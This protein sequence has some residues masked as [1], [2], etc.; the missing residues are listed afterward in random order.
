MQLYVADYLGDTRHLT[1]EQHGAY[2][3]ILMTMWRSDG[4]LPNDPK[5]LARITGCNGSRWAR[6][7]PEVMEFFDVEGDQITNPRLRLELEKAQEKSNQRAVAG[8]KGGKANVLK[9]NNPVEANATALPNHSSEPEPDKEREANASAGS[10][11]MPTLL[12]HG[13][14]EA[15]TAKAAPWSADPNFAAAWAACTDKGRTRS[16]RKAAWAEWRKALRAAPGPVLAAAMARYVA[17]D[18]D[19]KRTGGP[20]F[21]IWLKDAKFEH[22]IGAPYAPD[23]APAAFNGPAALRESVVALMGEPF[24]RSWIDPCRWDAENRT[25]IARNGYAASKLNTELE[26]WMTRNKVKAAVLMQEAA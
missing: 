15:V 4:R 20:G 3:L 5:K 7:A 6:I 18:D 26:A 19:A 24:A 14:P 8:A 17:G 1:T 10:Q 25:L 11:A 9:N 23:F 13:E 2:L 22:W 12:D 16:S 21:H